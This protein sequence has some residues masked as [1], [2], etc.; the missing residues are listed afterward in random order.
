MGFCR[1]LGVVLELPVWYYSVAWMDR[2]G[3]QNCQTICLFFCSI[4]LFWYGTMWT[5]TQALYVEILHGFS[6]ALPYASITVFIARVAP[7]ETKSTLQASILVL[8]GGLG[9]GTG[10]IIGGI[11][12]DYFLGERIQLLFR[13]CGMAMFGIATAIIVHD[14]S[15]Y[16]TT[17]STVYGENKKQGYNVLGA[18]AGTAIKAAGAAS[19]FSALTSGAKKMMG[20]DVGK[21]V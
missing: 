5:A 13:L 18:G 6:F 2:I 15:R 16:I 4:R 14:V 1:L 20:K 12:I 17:G 8:F 3:I 10:A 11:L 7:E 21:N 19:S 9:T